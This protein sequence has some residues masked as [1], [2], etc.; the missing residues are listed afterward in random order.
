MEDTSNTKP[1]DIAT[2]VMTRMIVMMNFAFMTHQSVY[3]P[4]TRPDL[5]TRDTIR[6]GLGLK[7][8]TR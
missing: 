1:V 7:I 4:S 8:S 3:D 2:L 6:D 5:P